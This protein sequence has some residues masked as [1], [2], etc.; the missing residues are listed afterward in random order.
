VGYLCS[1]KRRLPE[2]DALVGYAVLHHAIRIFRDEGK[3]FLSLGL[4]PLCGIEDKELSS[5]RLV[6]FGFRMVYRSQL[7]N[8]LI[9][10][11]QGFAAHKGAFCGSAEQTYCAFKRGLTLSQLVKMPRASNVV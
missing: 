9:Y 2:A 1:A 10:P 5:N 6:S 3:A 8:Q 4:S 11:L 7:F